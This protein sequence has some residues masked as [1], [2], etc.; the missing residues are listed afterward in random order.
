[1]RK[2]RPERV[3]SSGG[4]ESP[5]RLTQLLFAAHFVSASWKCAPRAGSRGL[6]RLCLWSCELPSAVL[7]EDGGQQWTEAWV[8]ERSGAV[9]ESFR[10]VYTYYQFGV[11]LLTYMLI[12][13]V[14]CYVST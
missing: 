2:L 14:N 13:M 7:P 12:M 4:R 10:K 5:Q 6:T 1:M 9:L 3:T 11:Q 8:R